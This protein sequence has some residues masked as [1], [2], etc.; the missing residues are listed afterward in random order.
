MRNEVKPI[1]DRFFATITNTYENRSYKK[2]DSNFKDI[3]CL[4]L[5]DL[6]VTFFKSDY[7]FWDIPYVI[8][9]LCNSACA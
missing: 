4:V 1:P 8:N 2:A 5:V 9:D 6:T 7:R 3:L